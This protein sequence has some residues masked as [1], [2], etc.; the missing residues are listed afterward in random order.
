METHR[1]TGQ[2]RWRILA[3]SVVLLA[4]V[5]AVSKAEGWFPGLARLW[6]GS[7]KPAA[8][9]DLPVPTRISMR[10]FSTSYNDGT[11]PP[12]R[13]D[14]TARVPAELAE[15]LAFYRTELGK[16]GWQE[17]A[18]SVIAAERAELAFASPEGPATLKL[19]R[20]GRETTISLTQRN[21]ELAT[22]A[23]IVP[24][25]GQARLIFGYLA[26]DVAALAINGQT[27][28]VAG[29]AGHPQTLD[30]PAGTYSYELRVA[31]RPAS[32]RTIT[33]AV[34]ET[35]DLRLGSE[36]DAAFQIY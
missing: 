3:C 2:A 11:S 10:R 33:V 5:P 24:M 27:I 29:G 36:G 9:V 20:A 15:V 14:L 12:L 16:R 30:L 32:R 4:S 31:G 21:V 35:W 13:R 19:G 28:P 6:N 34:G 22:K 17:R 1:K 26:T 8:H 25:P 7:L 23:D 18:G